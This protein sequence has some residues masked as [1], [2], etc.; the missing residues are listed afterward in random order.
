MK[1]ATSQTLKKANLTNVKKKEEIKKSCKC[2]EP[3][4]KATLQ[5]LK[6]D[7]LTISKK[8]ISLESEIT[9][10]QNVLFGQTPSAT[11]EWPTKAVFSTFKDG[12]PIWF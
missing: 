12:K 5:T 9:K 6:K 3:L 2:E 11:A 10:R 1:K 4:K 7:N 8:T